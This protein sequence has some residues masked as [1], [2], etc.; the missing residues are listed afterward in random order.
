MII[1]AAL[2][3]AALSVIIYTTFFGPISIITS[4]M[5]LAIKSLS[6]VSPDPSIAFK[7]IGPLSLIAIKLIRDLLWGSLHPSATIVTPFGFYEFFIGCRRFSTWALSLSSS[8]P[9]NLLYDGG[10]YPLRL[11]VL[12]A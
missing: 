12:A 10:T 1:P 3:T 2:H 8:G 7:N 4:L 5:C 6:F 11:E 9:L